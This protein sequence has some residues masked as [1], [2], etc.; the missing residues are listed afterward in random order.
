MRGA[1]AAFR[2]YR[3][4]SR[5]DRAAFLDTIAAEIEARA[6][7]ITATASA[8]TGL[9]SAR[10]EG[11]CA[12]P[13]GQLRLFAHHIEKGAYLDRRHGPALP[14]RRPAPRPDLRLV[15]RPVGPVV[16]FGASVGAALVRHPLP[17]AVGFTGSLRSG[18][19]LFDL[20][21]AQPVPIPFFGELG[22]VNPGFL[23]PADLA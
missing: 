18:R 8:E 15:Q 21:A 11:E 10:I 6:A 16:V 23:L 13:T 20:C 12:R 19:A 7:L 1:A 17:Q 5:I 14:D 3:Q 22:N 9:P 4:N 2:L